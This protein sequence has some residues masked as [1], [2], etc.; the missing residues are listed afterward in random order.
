MLPKILRG[1][2]LPPILEAFQDVFPFLQPFLSRVLVVVTD[3]GRPNQ[4]LLQ[5]GLERTPQSSS[6]VREL[7]GVPGC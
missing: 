5:A 1:L 6:H 4:T 7:Q 2:V 3:P